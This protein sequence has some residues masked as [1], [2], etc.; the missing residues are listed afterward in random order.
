[1]S[2]PPTSASASSAD[3]PEEVPESG[4]LT[5]GVDAATGPASVAVVRDG[6][7]VANLTGPEG[8]QTDGWI[9]P[10]LDGALRRAGLSL[11]DLELLAVTVG[12]GAFT[13]IRVGIATCLG[14]AAARDLPVAGIGT[15]EALAEDAS[16]EAGAAD[17]VLACHDARRG[18]VYAALYEAGHIDTLPLRARRPPEVLEPDVLLGALQLEVRR[19]KASGAA[20]PGEGPEADAPVRCIGH[21]SGLAA[22]PELA[23]AVDLVVA[24]EAGLAG[25]AARLAARTLAAGRELPPPR[26]RYLRPP[27]IRPRASPLEEPRGSSGPV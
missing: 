7:V 20:S 8:R 23:A 1:M 21:G 15:L 5:V 16:S 19:S 12:P 22:Y 25:A 18:Q 14:V 17:L 27:D 26:P 2:P 11:E 4:P 10:A 6:E 13:G 3:A 24:R 9:F